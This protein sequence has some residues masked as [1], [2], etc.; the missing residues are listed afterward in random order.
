MAAD[1]GRDPMVRT[2]SPGPTTEAGPLHPRLRS[3]SRCIAQISS[4][5][6]AHRIIDPNVSQGWGTRRKL[7]PPIDTTLFNIHYMA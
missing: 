4:D 7:G 3:I 1:A 6:F 5:A 2:E